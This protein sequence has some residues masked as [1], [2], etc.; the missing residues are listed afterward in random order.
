MAS[1]L[2]LISSA[3]Q[4]FNS[5]SGIQC[6]PFASTVYHSFGQVTPKF[7]K[8][9]LIQPG[10]NLIHGFLYP[11]LLLLL[12]RFSR[13]QLCATLETTAH[14]APPSLGFSRQENWS[15]LPFPSPF[16]IPYLLQFWSFS[17][18]K[19][20]FFK[21]EIQQLFFLY[22]SHLTQSPFKCLA[23]FLCFQ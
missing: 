20:Q 13:A 21:L 23:L 9:T 17:N 5:S 3:I 18:H 14:Q 4:E 8:A 15:G 16:C 7:F 1:H 22:L 12:S 2:A 11:M 10:Q 19:N 6:F